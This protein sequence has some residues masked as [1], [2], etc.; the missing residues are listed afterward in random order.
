MVEEKIGTITE[1][2][3]MT[4]VGTGLEKGN[5]PETITIICQDPGQVQ[6]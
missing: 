4:E 1:V 5:F 2:T 6:R 3:G